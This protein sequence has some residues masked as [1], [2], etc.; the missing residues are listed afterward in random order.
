MNLRH[1]TLL[2]GGKYR[3]V[4]FI[5]SGGFG[6]TY[7][8]EHMMLEKRVAIKE[9]FVKDFCNRDSSTARISV[10]TQGKQAL[11]DKLKCKFIEEAKA[12]ARMHHSGIVN[13]S[14][15]FEENGTAYYVMDYIEGR[16]LHDILNREDRLSEERALG[17]IRQVAE[18]L[19][20]VHD[21]HRLHLDVKPGNIMVDSKGNAILIDF[22]TSKQYDEENGEN[23]STVQGY[24]KGF[25]PP[26]QMTNDMVKFM[27]STDIYAL[28]ATLY[29]LLTGITPPSATLRISGEGLVALPTS[30]SAATKKAI[31]QAMQLNKAMRPQTVEAF[32]TLLGIPST[33]ADDEETDLDIN[34]NKDDNVN[35]RGDE[36]QGKS[37]VSLKMKKL[38]WPV[39]ACV[40][41]ALGFWGVGLYN[42]YCAKRQ[43]YIQAYNAAKRDMTKFSVTTTPSG[44]M[45]YIDGKK[46]GVTPIEG[47]EIA[48][49]SH[50]VKLGK[51]GYEDKNLTRMFG[52]KPVVINETLAEKPKPQQQSQSTASSVTPSGN[53]KTYTVNGV[54]FTMVKVAGGTFTMGASSSDSDAYSD[55]KPAHSVT[56]SSYSIGETEVTQALWQAVMGSNPS[57]FKG[58]LQRPVERVSWDDCQAFIRKLN[59]L[60]GATFRLPTEAEWEYAARGGSQSRGYK[61]SGSRN[62]GTVAW[63]KGNSSYTTHPVKTKQ[64]NELGL[65]DMAGNVWEWCADWYDGSYYANSPSSNPKGPST[66]PGRVYRGGSWYSFAEYCRVSARQHDLEESYEES[67]ATLAR[68][69]LRLVSQ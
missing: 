9:F 50:Q 38:L 37:R 62:L 4:R 58:N 1:D 67:L 64:P 47:E 69:G 52:D 40:A 6:C 48:R 61:Y 35:H 45:V 14:D 18:A 36:H 42:E 34:D 63:Y 3:I 46:M 39:V 27:P 28:G 68:I 2:Q 23:T 44:A 22:G 16:S 41:V 49:G 20:Y 31:E 43:A 55:E 53:K 13:V 8:A 25:A 29:K 51:E 11:V 30:V 7:V 60:T 5:S 66:G 10:A 24:T 57:S 32:L 26:E 12:L 15:V 65:Y 17:Y 59:S 21:Q 19:A 54:S 56:L 33:V